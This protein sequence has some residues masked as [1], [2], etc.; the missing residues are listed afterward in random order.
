MIVLQDQYEQK[1]KDSRKQIK[2]INKEKDNLQKELN[3][4]SIQLTERTNEK[5]KL[6]I[7]TEQVTH[8]S[9]CLEP[10]PRRADSIEQS[11]QFIETTTR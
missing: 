2:Q 9:F 8:F 4:I 5:V 11:D 6:G 3:Q 10:T 7:K 1:T